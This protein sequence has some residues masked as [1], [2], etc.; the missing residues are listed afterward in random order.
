MP[1]VLVPRRDPAGPLSIE[2]DGIVP[3]RV[4]GLSA[5]EVARLPIRADACPLP[6]GEVFDVTGAGDDGRIECRGDFS[7][8]HRVGAGM[9]S[10][11]MLVR[12]PA[13]R[14]AGARMTG[15]TLVIEGDAG[16]WLAA[17]MSGGE[18][19]VAGAAGDNL[20]GA[21]PGS[22]A[23]LR[24]GVVLV[25][26]GAGDLAAARMR[27]GLVAI[28]G[29]CGVA[30]GFEM[31]AGTLVVAGGCG[32]QPGLGMRRGTIVA[33]GGVSALPATFARGCRWSP[34]LLP[35]LLR[36]LVRAGFAPAPAAPA[37]PWRQWHGDL[38]A[39]GRG[40]LFHPE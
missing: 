38:L 12:G 19:R 36:R 17:E 37:G 26:G 10:G 5:A 21:R 35:L 34:P 22:D 31:R 30:A 40:E 13:G 1:L 25:A 3:D 29:R 23:G 32:P 2:L 11:R 20:A 18:V 8:V 28:G 39:G 6:L 9:A 24:G 14:H 16:D 15:G 27:R 33:P 7:R 4:A